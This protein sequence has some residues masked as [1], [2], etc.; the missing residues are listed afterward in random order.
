MLH[1]VEGR[2]INPYEAPVVELALPALGIGPLR[3]EVLPLGIGRYQATADLRFAGTLGAVDPR[4][5]RRVRIGRGH[6]HGGDRVGAETAPVARMSS[7]HGEQPHEHDADDL[8]KVGGL[9][10]ERDAAL[11][12]VDDRA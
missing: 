9:V 11:G 7:R 8:G 3:P 10:E 1:D 5:D 4:A 2:I 12:E 6:H